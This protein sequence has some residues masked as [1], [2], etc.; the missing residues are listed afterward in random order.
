VK[1]CGKCF[2]NTDFYVIKDIKL[3]YHSI[4]FA[5]TNDFLRISKHFPGLLQVLNGRK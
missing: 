2:R 1:R 3:D 5:T 4:G